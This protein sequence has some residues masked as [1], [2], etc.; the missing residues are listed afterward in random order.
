MEIEK[1]VITT[2]TTLNGFRPELAAALRDGATGYEEGGEIELAVDFDCDYS[3]ARAG[4]WD[5]PDEPAT[6]DFTVRAGNVRLT[7]HEVAALWPDD[8]ALNRDVLAEV[9]GA[10]ADSEWDFD[11]CDL[12]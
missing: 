3:P 12:Y 4:G 7:D 1:Y 8:A 11:P 10:L 9:E 5:G 2:L 6:V